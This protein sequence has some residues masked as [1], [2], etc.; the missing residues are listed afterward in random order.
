VSNLSI[1][2]SSPTSKQC[3]SKPANA[4]RPAAGASPAKMI[5]GVA[6]QGA[7]AVLQPWTFARQTNAAEAPNRTVPV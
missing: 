2:A 5:D 4:S 6:H 3:T 7:R 1:C